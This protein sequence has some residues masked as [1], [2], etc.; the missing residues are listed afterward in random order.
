MGRAGWSGA[1]SEPIGRLGWSWPSS[2]SFPAQTARPACTTDRHTDKQTH[3]QTDYSLGRDRRPGVVDK[4][5]LPHHS[6]S[7]QVDLGATQ[8]LPAVVLVA[9]SLGDATELTRGLKHVLHQRAAAHLVSRDLSRRGGGTLKG[10]FWEIFHNTRVFF[11]HI[12]TVRPQTNLWVS[13]MFR[14]QNLQP[15][16]VRFTL[17][18]VDVAEEAGRPGRQTDRQVSD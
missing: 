8:L 14:T 18:V 3:R 12:V 10:G 16:A 1:A 5:L 7:L 17:R 4:V 15:L 6:D 9:F 2:G 13:G 11:I